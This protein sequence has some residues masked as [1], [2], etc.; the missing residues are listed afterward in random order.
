MYSIILVSFLAAGY[1]GKKGAND[2]WQVGK[3]Q[4]ACKLKSFLW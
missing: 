2:D 3:M 4:L 1:S